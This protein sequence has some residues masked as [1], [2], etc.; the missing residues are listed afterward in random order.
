MESSQKVLKE[1]ITFIVIAFAL[2]SIFYFFL[3]SRGT[4]EAKGRL[5]VFGL[6]WCPGIAGLITRLLFHRNIRGFGWGWGKTRYQIIG[7]LLPF[8]Y[9]SIAYVIVWLSGL[10]S[11][12]EEFSPNYLLLISLG[13]ITNCVFALGEEIGWRG[14]LVPQLAR[15]TDFTKTSLITGVI[16]S[17]WHYPLVIFANY[18]SGTPAWYGLTCFTVMA[19]G[20]TFPLTWIRLKS[21]SVW[22]AMFFHASH[23][24][25]IQSFF[26]PLTKDTGITKFIIGEFGAALAVISVIVAYIFWRM[27]SSLPDTQLKSETEVLAE[28]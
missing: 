4:L 12:N 1:I 19:V 18:N 11:I 20:M 2:S 3:I 24:L 8:S 22:T 14:F 13:T 7:Y 17:I 23:N 6:M 16:W 5:Y 26:N 27:R 9:A 15:L 25:Y 21:G 10:G 28:S